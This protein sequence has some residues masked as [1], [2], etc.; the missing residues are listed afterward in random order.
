M[1]PVSA[2]PF[3]TP[4]TTC[5]D[6]TLT[7]PGSGIFIVASASST[8]GVDGILGLG[9]EALLSCLLV[10]FITATEGADA[11]TASTTGVTGADFDIDCVN[12]EAWSVSGK[13]N[14]NDLC[15][16]G[17]SGGGRAPIFFSSSSSLSARL[18]AKPGFAYKTQN[19]R[20][21]VNIN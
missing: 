1:L 10:P 16:T 7:G 20:K 5:S 18:L 11:S 17:L 13:A 21:E 3:T 15:T 14:D 4:F 19:M 6:T 2:S 9:I 12:E 8:F